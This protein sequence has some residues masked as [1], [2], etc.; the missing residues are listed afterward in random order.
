MNDMSNTSINVKEIVTDLQHE[1]DENFKKRKIAKA[2]LMQTILSDWDQSKSIFFWRQCFENVPFHVIKQIYG[3]I[4]NLASDGYQ[5]NS[6]AG[7]F[8]HT[9]KEMGY[10]PWK[11]KNNN[12][13]NNTTE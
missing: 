2:R 13:S 4:K 11:E 1:N 9:L 6:N 3:N 7:F 10:F 8:V 12:E 5:I